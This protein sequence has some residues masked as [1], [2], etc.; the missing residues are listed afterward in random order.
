MTTIIAPVITCSPLP[1]IH[2]DYPPTLRIAFDSPLLTKETSQLTLCGLL[3]D[4][5][6]H[7]AKRKVLLTQVISHDHLTQT[8]PYNTDKHLHTS[9]V[10][11][12]PSA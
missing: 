12:P 11:H 6:L 5:F 2:E 3:V 10:T 8:I 4:S 1:K 7:Q 9:D